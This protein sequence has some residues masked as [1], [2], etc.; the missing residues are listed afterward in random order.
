[1]LANTV[2]GGAFAVSGSFNAIAFESFP[3]IRTVTP[4]SITQYKRANYDSVQSVPV[5]DG[6]VMISP[7]EYVSEFKHLRVVDE[8]MTTVSTYQ[9]TRNVFRSEET[10]TYNMSIPVGTIYNIPAATPTTIATLTLPDPLPWG[11]GEINIV[12]RSGI[13][14][15]GDAVL[16][17]RVY[18]YSA[19]PITYARISNVTS[20]YSKALLGVTQGTN[21]V[22]ESATFPV[23]YD[24]REIYQIDLQLYSTG[25]QVF[26]TLGLNIFSFASHRPAIKELSNTGCIAAYQAVTQLQMSLAGVAN[27]EVIPRYQ[28][29][30]N[31]PV[32]Y[33][34]ELDTVSMIARNS[35]IHQLGS[36]LRNV[37]SIPDFELSRKTGLFN[38]SSSAIVARASSMSQKLWRLLDTASPYL[39][40]AGGAILGVATGNPMLGKAAGSI[41]QG[42]YSG[43]R[44]SGS[45]SIVKASSSVVRC[46]SEMTNEQLLAL[47]RS[48][49][50]VMAAL[51]KQAAVDQQVDTFTELPSGDV[52]KY[53]AMANAKKN[54][55]S[56]AKV[57]VDSKNLTVTPF[58]VRSVYDPIPPADKSAFIIN[59]NSEIITSDLRKSEYYITRFP[60]VIGDSA[61]VGAFIA[62]PKPVIDLNGNSPDYASV[63]GHLVDKRVA[64]MFEFFFKSDTPLLQCWPSNWKMYISVM[65]EGSAYAPLS[66]DSHSFAAFALCYLFPAK[67][68]YTGAKTEYLVPADLNVK[69]EAAVELNT[70]IIASNPEP[71]DMKNFDE[72]L[73]GSFKF[74]MLGMGNYDHPVLLDGGGLKTWAYMAGS[75]HFMASGGAT[76]AAAITKSAIIASET[77]SQKAKQE[78]AV[79][80]SQGMSTSHWKASVPLSEIQSLKEPPAPYDDYVSQTQDGK[81]WWKK[82]QYNAG[83]YKK[84]ALENQLIQANSW[85]IRNEERLRNIQNAPQPKPK[86]D[87]IAAKNKEKL[88]LLKQASRRPLAM[89]LDEV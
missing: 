85:L 80:E 10:V 30:R 5:A 24:D 33:N 53:I 71:V 42:L 59:G 70:K 29:T 83:A 9:L 22:F 48:N 58:L 44:S 56:G 20:S 61:F 8:Q 86:S 17:A 63:R 60:V 41:A 34:V 15:L 82:V 13:A 35:Y 40:A 43:M 37:Y 62:S 3:P 1:M 23:P 31:V 38:Q 28:L 36:S 50:S 18:R 78:K 16:I 89:N 54:S 57:I 55:V 52:T 67:F 68:L 84:T 12:F 76:T 47:I 32:G 75:L 72:N 39:T 73:V 49:P 4:Q 81:S 79:Y 87:K 2:N 46:S 66:G 51:T 45:N 69:A 88:A 64:H 21:F 11:A 27:F 25:V 77:Q 65:I 14:V 74:M 26:N 7:L 19:D 6:I